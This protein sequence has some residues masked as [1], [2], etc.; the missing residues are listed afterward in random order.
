M[1]AVPADTADAIPE[2]ELIDKTAG[3]ELVH[4]PPD[5]ALL[6]V[7]LVP[8]HNV[9][10]PMIGD[11]PETTAMCLLTEHPEAPPIV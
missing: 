4:V 8:E 9:D 3:L 5:V 11:G 7:A 6:R 10:G 1:I 2:T